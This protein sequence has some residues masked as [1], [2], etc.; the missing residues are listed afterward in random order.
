[1]KS[2]KRKVKSTKKKKPLMR[3]FFLVAEMGF[4]ILF[5]KIVSKSLRVICYSS[6]GHDELRN[7]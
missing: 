3:L 4:V 2:E 6:G 7:V 1:M 5:L